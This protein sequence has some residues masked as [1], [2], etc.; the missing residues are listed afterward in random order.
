MPAGSSERAVSASQFESPR[1]S[2]FEKSSMP[3]PLSSKTMRVPSLVVSVDT[4][5]SLAPARRRPGPVR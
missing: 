5:I 2:N 4:A 1:C 3:A